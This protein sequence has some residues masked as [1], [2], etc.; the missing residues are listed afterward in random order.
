MAKQDWTKW[1]KGES[2]AVSLFTHNP[3][4][5]WSQSWTVNT[6]FLPGDTSLCS[7]AISALAFLLA[8]QLLRVHSAH[9]PFSLDNTITL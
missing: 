6:E 4:Q 8:L 9:V 3:K 2:G 1:R 7:L 5:S